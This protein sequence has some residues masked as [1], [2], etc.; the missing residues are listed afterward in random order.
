MRRATATDG[1]YVFRDGEGLLRPP[2]SKSR[3]RD[4]VLRDG[5]RLRVP[6]LLMDGAARARPARRG[7]R[8]L[9]IIDSRQLATARHRPGSIPLTDAARDRHETLIRDRDLRLSQN[10]RTLGGVGGYRSLRDDWPWPLSNNNNGEIDPDNDDDDD[11]DDDDLDDDDQDN[12]GDDDELSAE[13][14]AELAYQQRRVALGQAWKRP[15]TPYYL[16]P[17][18]SDADIDLATRMSALMRTGPIVPFTASAATFAVPPTATGAPKVVL[19]FGQSP[20]APS[21]DPASS[22]DAREAAMAERDRRL[23]NAWKGDSNS[24]ADQ[25]DDPNNAAAIEKQRERW[26]GRGGML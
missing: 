24:S 7:V 20:V 4:D 23:S 22:A 2:R 17:A 11:D 10:W 5:E 21:R 13:D 12:N 25:D 15:M 9:P 14:Q 8:P 1:N 6:L 18:G 26:A 16:R 3:K 19:G